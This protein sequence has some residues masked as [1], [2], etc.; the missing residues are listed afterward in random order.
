MVDLS[1]QKFT[2]VHLSLAVSAAL[3]T[4][5]RF[6]KPTH[7]SLKQGQTEQ[8]QQRV[9]LLYVFLRCIVHVNH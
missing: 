7:L 5:L 8:N 6:D 9:R 4:Q 2:E 3:L 1:F